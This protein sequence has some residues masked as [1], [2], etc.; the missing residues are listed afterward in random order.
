MT[1]IQRFGGALNLNVHFHMLLL[2]SVYV[3]RP[4]ATLRIRRVGAPTTAELEALT[5][6]LA[7][8][9]GRLLERRGLVERDAEN[10]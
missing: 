1:L 7:R 8:R 5:G 2:D 3:G 10:A 4:D 9:I 6:T